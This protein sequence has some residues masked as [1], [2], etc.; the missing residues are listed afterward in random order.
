MS[1][2]SFENPYFKPDNL[3]L[4]FSSTVKNAIIRINRIKSSERPTSYSLYL[5]LSCKLQSFTNNKILLKKKTTFILTFS[6]YLYTY[7]VYTTILE[8]SINCDNQTFC[9]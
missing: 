2:P 4:F 3:R 8:I 6:G 1:I 9:S 7:L 5:Y